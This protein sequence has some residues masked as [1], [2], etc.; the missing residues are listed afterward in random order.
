MSDVAPL[1][2][3]LW[4]R[5]RPLS[6]HQLWEATPPHFGPTMNIDPPRRRVSSAS[7]DVM[8]SK[9]MKDAGPSDALAFLAYHSP[10]EESVCLQD[11]RV[12]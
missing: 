10:L 11:M 3:I 12:S 1:S 9:E 8:L 5:P 4:T 7:S 2:V 6:S